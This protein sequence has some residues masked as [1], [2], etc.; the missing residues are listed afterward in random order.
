MDLWILGSGD[1]GFM[2][3]VILDLWIL[4]LGFGGVCDLGFCDLGE[5]A[6]WDLWILDL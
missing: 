5:L 2:D 3:H 4:L 6:I 1:F